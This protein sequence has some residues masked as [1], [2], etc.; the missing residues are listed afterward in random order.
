MIGL[1]VYQ[2]VDEESDSARTSNARYISLEMRKCKEPTLEAW[3]DPVIE[4]SSAKGRGLQKQ[5]SKHRRSRFRCN[6]K[7]YGSANV[8]FI[9]GSSGIGK[10]ELAL[11]FAYR[12]SQW[13]KMVLWIGGEARYLRQNI[14]NL[15]MS[16]GLD[17]SAE[18]VKEKGRIRSFEE[19]ESD[20]F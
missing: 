4:L 1:V 6:S 5:R 7:S 18:A 11:E 12:Y 14:L 15:S 17:I 16:L 8:I 3:I 9:N 20:A 13:Y 19:Q 10:T 2:M